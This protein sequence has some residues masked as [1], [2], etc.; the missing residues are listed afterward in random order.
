L[1]FKIQIKLN[2]KFEFIHVF[3]LNFKNKDFIF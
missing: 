2:K 1:T 3:K